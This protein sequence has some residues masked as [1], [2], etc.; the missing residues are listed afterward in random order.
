MRLSMRLTAAQLMCVQGCTAK[1]SDMAWPAI[2]VQH[3]TAQ[4]SLTSPIA[5]WAVCI[6]EKVISLER[7]RVVVLMLYGDILSWNGIECVDSTIL[8][9]VVD[10]LVNILVILMR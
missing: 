2:A 6:G 10:Q 4:H 3:S 7:P 8:I 5:Y 9:D 1:Q